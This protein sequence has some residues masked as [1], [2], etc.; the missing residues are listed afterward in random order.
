VS[1]G[2]INSDYW[3]LDCWKA[4]LSVATPGSANFKAGNIAP[5]SP[6]WGFAFGYCAQI[7]I[8]GA[9]NSFA[10]AND[11]AVLYQ[12]IEAGRFQHLGFGHA[13]A[14]PVTLSFW[15]MA[16]VTGTFAVML[17]YGKAYAHNFTVNVANTWEYKTFTFPPDTTG[18]TTD[19]PANVTTVGA[20]LQFC[21]AAGS[22]QKVQTL[23]AWATWSK[24]STAAQ[25]NFFASVNNN[26]FITGVSLVPGSIAPSAAQ[27]SLTRRMSHEEFA[28]C[29]RYYQKVMVGHRWFSSGSF[30]HIYQ[31]WQPMRATPSASITAGTRVNLSSVQLIPDGPQSGYYDHTA[32]A[33]TV[34]V[35]AFS[36][37]A[38]LNARV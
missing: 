10:G 32:S 7:G 29:Q 5:T 17:A 1:N 38:W 2:W 9:G 21:F 35:Y 23:D 27:S 16:S 36:D 30:S 37:A 4:I 3:I 34:D 31:H 28:L 12:K 14:A 22:A 6:P 24:N 13:N 25:S 11:Q 19:W 8:Y 26:V 15:V 33:A 18:G 20:Y